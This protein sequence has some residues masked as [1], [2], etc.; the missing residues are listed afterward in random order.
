M[1]SLKLMYEEFLKN[2]DYKIIFKNKKETDD[3][4]ILYNQV[5]NKY[6]NDKTLK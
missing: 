3:F 2:E 5:L 6:L 4:H 1:M